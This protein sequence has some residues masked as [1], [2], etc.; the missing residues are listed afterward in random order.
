MTEVRYH[1]LRPEQIVAQR[2]ECPVA[3]IPLGVLEWHGLHNPVG[4]DGL[5]AEG[6]AV[7]CAQKGGGLVFPTLYYGESRTEMLVDASSE[8]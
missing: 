8:D 1:L 6:L 4:A 2:R 5:Q 3:Y 7:L